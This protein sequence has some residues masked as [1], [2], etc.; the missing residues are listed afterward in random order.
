MMSILY[1]N[2]ALILVGFLH[3]FQSIKYLSNAQYG[4]A[5]TLFCYAV[6]TI[7][8]IWAAIK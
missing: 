3:G 6:S 8:I 5:L 4:L 2:W 7:G 1:N